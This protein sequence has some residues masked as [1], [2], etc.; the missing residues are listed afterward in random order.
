MNE[1]RTANRLEGL[2]MTNPSVA[3][4]DPMQGSFALAV[5]SESRRKDHVLAWLAARPLVELAHVVLGCFFARR[6][7][8]ERAGIA[9][10]G[11]RTL[12]TEID[13]CRRVRGIH[14]PAS[15]ALPQPHSGVVWMGLS[16]RARARPSSATTM[17]RASRMRGRRPNTRRRISTS[18]ESRTRTFAN[19]FAASTLPAAVKEAA[20]ANLSTLAT[21]TCFRTAD[22]EFHGF[23]GSDDHRGCCFGN[24]T[25]VWNYETAT[26]FLFPSY[27]R[28][29]RQAA[30]G[31]SMDDQGGMRFRQLLPD[32]KERY[33]IAAADGQ[34]GQIIHAYLDWKLSGDEA[35]LKTMWPRV[36]KAVEFAWIPGRLGCE[37]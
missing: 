3:G 27:A 2:L 34:M 11:R 28:S 19:A 10:R 12:P 9:Q 4:G 31:Y 30:F 20:S 35:W 29:L 6:R 18:L 7:T 22:G 8:A 21:T 33:H 5:L 15:L 13:S 14:F 36:K 37:P 25:H 1:Y 32:G 23:E 26:A 16:R 17:P 24:C